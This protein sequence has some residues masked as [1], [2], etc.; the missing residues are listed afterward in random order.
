MKA[1]SMLALKLIAHSQLVA[2]ILAASYL[3]KLDLQGLLQILL[4]VL[5]DLF[6][7]LDAV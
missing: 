1:A 3:P 7:Q 2:L 4:I 6:L 5:R